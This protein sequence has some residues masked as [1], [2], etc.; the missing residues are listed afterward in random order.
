M[1]EYEYLHL[2]I[3]YVTS[4]NPNTNMKV[5]AINGEE[6]P[7]WKTDVNLPEKLNQL[8]SEGW[9]LIDIVWRVIN[10]KGGLL[11]PLYILKRPK[12]NISF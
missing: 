5:K 9:E 8:G 2:T 1:Q 12:L 3:S 10:N 7:N 11:D 4:H 6:I